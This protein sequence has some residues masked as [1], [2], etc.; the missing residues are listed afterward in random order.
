LR[1]FSN[2]IPTTPPIIVEKI[3]FFSP[4]DGKNDCKIDIEKTEK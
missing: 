3:E 4:K 1:D 2:T